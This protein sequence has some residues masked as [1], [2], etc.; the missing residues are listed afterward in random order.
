MSRI[1]FHSPS[2]TSE[3]RGAERAHFGNTCR[4]VA[5]ALLH[6]HFH[7][8]PI[9]HLLPPGHY[10]RETFDPRSFRSWFAVGD[11]QGF[12]LPDSRRVLPFTVALNTVAVAGDD[13]LRFMARVHGQCELHGYIEGAHR[14]W[15]ADLI[16]QGRDD[17]LLRAEMGWE[18]VATLL[19]SR[20]DEPVVTSYSVC[21]QFPN[22]SIAGWH[23]NRYGDG[24]YEL[25]PE[26][27]WSRALAGLRASEDGL[28]WIPDRWQMFRF[29]DGITAMEVREIA[30]AVRSQER[31]NV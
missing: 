23:D 22:P 14:E 29:G 20:D 16:A 21:E 19:R 25:P 4:D 26:E 15:F 12:V 1:Y 8:D 3:V 2:G 17:R 24:F 11:D 31:P 5:L 6:V 18:S 30:D 28:E 13:V 27:R 10:L 7:D 9:Q